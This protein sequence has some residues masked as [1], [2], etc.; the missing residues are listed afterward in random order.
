[1]I[2]LAFLV[3]CLYTAVGVFRLGVVIR[4]LRC[5]GRVR[6]CHSMRCV[7]WSRGVDRGVAGLAGCDP[8]H[9]CTTHRQLHC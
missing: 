3:A 2:Q 8:K 6:M 1:V 9:S 7:W 4:F 5:A